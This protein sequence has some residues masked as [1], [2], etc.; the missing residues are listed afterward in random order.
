MSLPSKLALL[1]IPL[2]LALLALSHYRYGLAGQQG[3]LLGIVPLLFAGLLLGRKGLWLTAVAYL[4]ILL[5]GA[6]TDQRQGTATPPDWREALTNLLQPVLGYAILALILDRLVV[7][8]EASRRQSRDLVLLY[9]Q[10]ESEVQEKERSQAQLLHSQRMDSLGKLAA[11]VAHDFNN[12]LSVILGYAT[13]RESGDTAQ[14]RLNDIAN[15]TRRGKQLTDKLMTLAR[16]EPAVRVTF[17]ANESL[18]DLLPMLESLLG[19]QVRVI[20]ALAPRPAWVRMDP[21]EFETSVLNITKNAGDAMGDDG[22]FRI[23]CGIIESEVRLRFIDSGCGMSTEVIANLFEPFF[24]TKPEQQGTGIGLAVVHHTISQSGGRIR[25]D[26]TPGQG[27]S[28]DLYLPLQE[29]P[30]ASA[31]APRP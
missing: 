24:T 16:A 19:K 1:L 2:G 14:T 26:S 23:E 18:Q 3:L 30:A 9:R 4:L 5:I 13:L 15:A 8:S 6:W 20:V 10:L 28:I 31:Q 17:D 12:L 21:I 27:T 25:V 11:N 22:L 7:K 29:A